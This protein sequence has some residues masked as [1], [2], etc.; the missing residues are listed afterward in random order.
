MTEGFVAFS[1]RAV[2]IGSGTGKTNTPTASEQGHTSA[3]KEATV[4]YKMFALGIME[5][6]GETGRRKKEKSDVAENNGAQ[7]SQ[8]S[9]ETAKR[10]QKGGVWCLSKQVA[11]LCLPQAIKGHLSEYFL[12][13]QH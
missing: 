11:A 5:L 4:C 1:A 13:G 9:R 3:G 8:M 6:E 12:F 2:C 10:R 7:Q